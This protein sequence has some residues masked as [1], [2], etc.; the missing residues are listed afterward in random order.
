MLP[1]NMLPVHGRA[2][3]EQ[4]MRAGPPTTLTWEPQAAVVSSSGDLGYTW[5]FFE[6]RSRSDAKKAQKGKYVTIWRRQKDGSWK[7]ILDTGNPNPD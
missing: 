4:L 6:V 5:G 1:M 3:I 7:F 2:A